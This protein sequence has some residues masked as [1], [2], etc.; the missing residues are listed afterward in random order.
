MMIVADDDTAA[1][2]AGSVVGAICVLLL[3]GG[4]LLF[5]RKRNSDNT[6]EA[7]SAHEEHGKPAN[8][9]YG[10]VLQLQHPI[11]YEHIGNSPVVYDRVLPSTMYV[12]LPSGTVA[13]SDYEA[14]PAASDVATIVARSK[15]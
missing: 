10:I 9:N 1:I 12:T 7:S 11:A 5:L 13:M 8:A 2:V 3:I 4:F 14:A 6:P 15:V